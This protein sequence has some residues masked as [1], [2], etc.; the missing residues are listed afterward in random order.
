MF[1]AGIEALQLAADAR[2]QKRAAAVA[3]I[4]ALAEAA[5][6]YAVTRDVVQDAF[7]EIATEAAVTGR[8]GAPSVGEFFALEAS[9]VLGMSPG[10]LFTKLHEILS[11][12]H[13][14]PLLWARFLAGE[15]W[16][17]EV[18]EVEHQCMQVGPDVA[19][20]V[21]ELVDVARRVLPWAK[22]VARVPEYI[23]QV[24]PDF[25]R[26]ERARKSQQR[27]VY[28]DRFEHGSARFNGLLEAKDAVDFEAAIAGIA[29]ELPDPEDPDAVLTADDRRQIRRAAAVGEL[30]RSAFG[31]DVLPKHELVVHIQAED[32]AL[33][34]EDDGTGVARVDG[35]GE[36]LT[37]DL[38]RFLTGSKVTVRPVVDVRRLPAED[39]HDPSP[40]LRFAVQQRH[41]VEVFPHGTVDSRRCDLDHTVSYVDGEPGQT[42]AGN[43]GPLSRRAHRAKTFGGFRLEQPVPGVFHWTTP[44][45]WQF[46]VDEVGVTEIA[47]PDLSRLEEPPP[48]SLD[49]WSSPPEDDPPERLVFEADLL[50][51]LQYELFHADAWDRS[52]YWI[53]HLYSIR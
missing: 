51:T 9:A 8:I 30:A 46:R 11:V 29:R 18:Q 12:Q 2:K 14:H 31:Q 15:L 39:Q 17:H 34:P 10:G 20:R 22:V 21:D 50:Q 25:A 3:E 24:D 41:P 45:G 42:H 23:A 5:R 33:D 27:Y 53:D 1:K 35:W 49:P 48:D 43:L 26:A 28:V 38:P 13:R 32:P 37:E 40:A 4:V 16:W 44:H 6:Q 7:E 19:K 36:L 47:A 52:G